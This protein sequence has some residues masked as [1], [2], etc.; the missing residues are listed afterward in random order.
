MYGA[1]GTLDL[2]YPGWESCLSGP[3]LSENTTLLL[4]R[5]EDLDSLLPNPGPDNPDSP[6]PDPPDLRT[7]T[8]SSSSET[9]T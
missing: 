1:D 6:L 7:Q 4:P 2:V 8:P 9:W 3:L 5:S